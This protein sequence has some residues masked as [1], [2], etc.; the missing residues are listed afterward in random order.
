MKKNVTA[1]VFALAIII[2]AGLLSH[3]Y[4]ERNQPIGT[5]SVT[6]LGELNFTSDLIVWEGQFYKQAPDLESAY[7]SLIEDKKKIEAYLLENGIAEEELIFNAV[8]INEQRRSIYDDGNYVGEEF[9]GYQLAQSFTI[10]SKQVERIE[11]IAREITDLLQKGVNLY[12]SPPR[13]YY[14]DLASLKLE[15]VSMATQDA[16][17]RAEKISENSNS[18][19]GRVIEAKMGVFQI[20]G[21]N[22]N[23]DYSWGGT[24]NTKDKDKTASITLK[25]M[26]AVD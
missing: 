11:T 8:E 13:Y 10:Q 2:S 22:S 18:Q 14:T 4:I 15:L 20:T 1:I 16:R 26:Y 5:L 23:E 3:A 9:L 6:G 21:Q 17:E 7:S 25:L 24:F 19:L 12:S